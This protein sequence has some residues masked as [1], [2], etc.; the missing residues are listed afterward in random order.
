MRNVLAHPLAVSLRKTI[1]DVP[2]IRA[3]YRWWMARHDYEEA[4][5]KRLLASITPDSVVWDIGANVGLYTKEC[6]EAGAR[7]V[8]SFE[9]APGSLNVLRQVAAQFPGRVVVMDVALSDA[10]GTSSFLA[11]ADSVTNRLVEAGADVGKVVQVRMCRGEDLLT[12]RGV[13]A[14]S[15]IKIDVEGFEVEV[16]RGL[17]KVLESP[18]LNHVMVEI[19]FR[20]LDLRGLKDG[21][22]EICRRLESAGFKVE[23]LDLSHIG[24]S[25]T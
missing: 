1:R 6:V 5:G 14:P 25:R 4:F 21:P 20:A 10:A 8:I 19:H 15:I 2:P 23:W 9:P 13:E 18:T 3:L 7:K 16:I 11:E 22:G 17:G 12:E 24:A